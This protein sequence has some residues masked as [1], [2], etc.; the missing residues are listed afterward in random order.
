M[1]ASAAQ[2]VSPLMIT[3]SHP[4]KR[5]S[6]DQKRFYPT[7]FRLLL[8]SIAKKAAKAPDASP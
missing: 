7:S 6:L 5:A 3:L 8:I 4:L 1:E 2:V